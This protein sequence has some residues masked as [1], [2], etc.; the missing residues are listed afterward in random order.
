MKTL[1][2][3]Q[4]EFDRI[5]S[6]ARIGAQDVA[7]GIHEIETGPEA[8]RQV[9]LERDAWDFWLADEAPDGSG[10]ADMIDSLNDDLSVST[11]RSVFADAL[12]ARLAE[13]RGQR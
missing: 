4:Q 11:A 13:L 12:H 6:A 3:P 2:I 9:G 7:D 5:M 10:P 1:K 8:F